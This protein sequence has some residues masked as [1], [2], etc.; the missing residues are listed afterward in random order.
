MYYLIAFTYGDYVIALQF[1]MEA[2]SKAVEEL[3]LNCREELVDAP[4]IQNERDIIKN[5]NR[6]EEMNNWMIKILDRF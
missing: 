6:S 1:H 4:Y 5:V 2:T 3:V